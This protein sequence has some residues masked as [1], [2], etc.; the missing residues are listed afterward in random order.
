MPGATGEFRH[1]SGQPAL[2][3]DRVWGPRA[4]ALAPKG[5]AGRFRIAHGPPPA[6]MP[7]LRFV[8]VAQGEGSGKRLARFEASIH[9]PGPTDIPVQ[10]PA[11]KEAVL[12]TLAVQGRGRRWPLIS[13]QPIQ[14][15][16][17]DR[18]VLGTTTVPEAPPSLP[19]A[20]AAWRTGPIQLDGRLDEA[21]WDQAAPHT[22]SDS[23]G[24]PG[25]RH[26]TTLKLLY[27]ERYL[28]VAFAAE[29]PDVRCPFAQATAPPPRDRP[30]YE[31]EAVELFLMPHRRAPDTGPY[32]ELQSSPSG[33]IFDAAF[34]GPRQGMDRGYNA[35]QQVATV[36]DGSLNAPGPD[37]GWRTEWRVPFTALR[38]VSAA[39]APGEVWRMN[40][41]RVETSRVSGRAQN[42]YTAWSP[43]HVGDFHAVHRFGHLLFGP[44]AASV[45]P[46]DRAPNEQALGDDA[47]P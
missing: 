17:S 25:P 8:L 9:A 40:A 11:A 24:R 44:R 26:S 20:M 22:L 10:A 14:R 31:H 41:F 29:D 4:D 28:Y 6:A 33:A 19:T 16:A 18:L 15:T 2:S 36:V 47:H 39:P 46:P 43:P 38:G 37:R 13:P 32:V 23:L 12:W 21:A 34:R 27:D 35:G 1:P 5:A 3:I 30:I 45:A 42:E 7:E